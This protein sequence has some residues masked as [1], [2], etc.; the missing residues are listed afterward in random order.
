MKITLLPIRIP[1]RTQ[2]KSVTP[3]QF[4]HPVGPTVILP[5]SPVGIFCLFFTMDILQYIVDQTNIYACLCM[6]ETAFESWQK[7]TV[8]ELE[9]FMGFMILMGLVRLPSL[10]DYWKTDSLFHYK[11]IADRI[12]RARYFELQ[13]YLHFADNR[14]LAPTG[15]LGYKKL[16]KVEPMLMMIEE[17]FQTL[18]N[19]SKEVSVDEAMVPFKCRSS[20]KQYVPLKPVKRGFKIWVLADAHTGYISRFDVYRGKSGEERSDGLG[21]NVVKKLCQNIKHRY[22]CTFFYSPKMNP[23]FVFIDT[24]MCSLTIIL[25]VSIFYWTCYRMAS[26]GVALYEVIVFGFLMILS[27]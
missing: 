26:M 13:R 20:M 11:P 14:Q 8:E 5:D 9:A 18:C 19:L 4:C 22:M 15:T 7:V 25:P 2:L 21:A 6:G 23:P 12:P 3:E 24:T 27:H 10:S 16:G 17:R 1:W